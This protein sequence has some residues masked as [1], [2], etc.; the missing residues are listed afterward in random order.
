M[1][2]KL[3]ENKKISKCEEKAVGIIQSEEQKGKRI[4]K[5]KA[6]SPLEHHQ[7]YQHMDNEHGTFTKVDYMLSHKISL[8]DF[9][10]KFKS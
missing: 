3:K 8:D 2:K 5:I 10:S 1:D 4:Q 9:F 7:M 6:K